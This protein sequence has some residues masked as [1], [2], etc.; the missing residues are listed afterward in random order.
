MG[1]AGAESPG[2]TFTSAVVAHTLI[3]AAGLAARGALGTATATA[4]TITAC[5]DLEPERLQSFVMM[6]LAWSRA[7]RPLPASAVRHA[8][9]FL[10]EEHPALHDP[11]ERPRVG[12]LARRWIEVFAAR[13]GRPCGQAL[14]RM[15][16][17]RPR[18][19]LVATRSP[20]SRGWLRV[21]ARLP[22]R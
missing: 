17:G 16:R 12:S 13:R 10:A 1:A 22:R 9:T 3:P 21:D 4:A 18:S 20:R 14:T 8:P 7:A 2:R 19:G 15:R 11:T 6:A 5:N